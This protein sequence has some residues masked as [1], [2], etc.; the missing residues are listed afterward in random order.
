M[1]KKVILADIAAAAGVSPATVDRVLNDRGGVGADKV[2]RVLACARELNIDRNLQQRAGPTVRVA[3]VMHDLSNPFYAELSQAFHL[4]LKSLPTAS[5]TLQ[6]YYCDILQP[7]STASLLRRLGREYDALIVAS[8]DHPLITSALQDITKQIPVV[9]MVSDL[10]FSGRR[11]YVGL[12]NRA[13]GRTAGELMGRFVGKQ[14]GGVAIVSGLQQLLCQGEREAGFRAV[15]AE[16]YP[17]CQLVA[18]LETR[19]QPDRTESLISQLLARHPDLVGIYNITAGDPGIATALRQAGREQDVV[20]ITHELT[21]DRRQLLM[22]GVIDVVVDQ[23]P[24]LE[25]VTALQ[26]V[27]KIVGLSDAQG[28]HNITPFTLY[29][30]ENCAN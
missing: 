24:A 1:V 14:G 16:R 17:A 9:T 28:E 5:M 2:Q 22:E 30:R 26:V 6:Q 18:V 19:E 27:A 13:A 12:D 3:V 21:S 11:E 20:F 7:Q 23:N 10:P 25:A 15:L 8:P 29:L 4:A